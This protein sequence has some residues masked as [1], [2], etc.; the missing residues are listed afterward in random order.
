MRPLVRG[1]DAVGFQRIEAQ[2]WILTTSNLK[3]GG[4]ATPYAEIVARIG[5]VGRIVNIPAPYIHT[6]TFVPA[7]YSG[8]GF[9][10][11]K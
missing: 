9:D 1:N 2:A 3:F 10:L 5:G 4:G 11:S 6:T 7:C 8:I